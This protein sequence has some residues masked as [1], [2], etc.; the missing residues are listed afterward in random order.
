[1]RFSETASEILD[2]FRQSHRRPG[3][4][5]TLAQLNARFGTD[6]VTAVAISELTHAG[7]VRAPDAETIELTAMGFDAVQRGD[8]RDPDQ[9]PQ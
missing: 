7:Y 8:Y 4:R 2:L 5:V 6:P 9:P 3:A 1:M